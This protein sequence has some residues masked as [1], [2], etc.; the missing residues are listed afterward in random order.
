MTDFFRK[1]R[2]NVTSIVGEALE[3]G[4]L[5]DADYQER[6]EQQAKSQQQSLPPV[7]VPP[8]LPPQQSSPPQI[9]PVPS[10]SA[11]VAPSTTS[12]Q[13]HTETPTTN[14]PSLSPSPPPQQPDGTGNSSTPDAAAGATRNGDS[15]AKAGA[16]KISLDKASREDLVNFVKKQAVVLKQRDAKI[17]GIVCS[18]PH[19]K[20]WEIDLA[21]LLTEYYDIS[22]NFYPTLQN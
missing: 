2:S 4:L 14:P 6:K 10:P 21:F 13:S 19:Y 22:H 11:S 17:Q 3:S 5:L 7:E 16:M 18:L 20:K 1:I 15:P 8:C 9:T 12:A